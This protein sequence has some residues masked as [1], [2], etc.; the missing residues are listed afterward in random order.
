MACC[1]ENHPQEAAQ[2]NLKPSARRGPSR[3]TPRPPYTGGKGKQ[4]AGRIA[5][6]GFENVRGS[7]FRVR[8]LVSSRAME[9]DSA[10]GRRGPRPSCRSA[11]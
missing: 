3:L 4:R 6:A 2:V 7:G 9:S 5:F 10:S 8:T 11:V 1:S